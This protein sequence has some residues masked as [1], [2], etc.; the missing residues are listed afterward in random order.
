MNN[1]GTVWANKKDSCQDEQSQSPLNTPE[2]VLVCDITAQ[3]LCGGRHT[4]AHSYKSSRRFQDLG[5]SAS[6]RQM[7]TQQ[8]LSSSLRS[9]D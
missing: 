2:K 7:P 1:G 4:T 8:K 3:L 9:I 6:R 5:G